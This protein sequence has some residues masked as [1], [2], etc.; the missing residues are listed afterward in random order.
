MFL[1]TCVKE[2]KSQYIQKSEHKK[3]NIK[4]LL[5]QNTKQKT[6]QMLKQN[7]RQ[8]GKGV[9]ERVLKKYSQPVL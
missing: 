9:T 8:K 7:L 1:K 6:A 3:K 5:K 4:A 2:F